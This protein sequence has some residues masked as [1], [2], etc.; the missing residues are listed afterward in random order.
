[1]CTF[2]T[3]KKEI[4]ITQAIVLHMNSMWKMNIAKPKRKQTKN[5]HMKSHFLKVIFTKYRS[6][7]FTYKSCEELQGV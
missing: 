5:H 2:R 6:A 3:D 7:L 1:M 4:G